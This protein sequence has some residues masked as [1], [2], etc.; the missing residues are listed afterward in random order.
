MKLLR[1]LV[2]TAPYTAVVAVIYVCLVAHPIYSNRPG[3]QC[4]LISV[5][6]LLFHPL[7]N[8]QGPPVAGLSDFYGAC[9]ALKALL[10]RRRRQD[11]L[12]YGEVFIM[13]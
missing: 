7:S 11:H 12:K 10:Y 6:R 3:M 9:F 13:S 8:F 5:Y 2:V 1:G 4:L